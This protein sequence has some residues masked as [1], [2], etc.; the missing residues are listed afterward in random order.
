MRV[1]G[2]LVTCGFEGRRCDLEGSYI[3]GDKTRLFEN[4]GHPWEVNHLA[5]LWKE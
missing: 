3:R 1:E 4:R 2:V 5:V